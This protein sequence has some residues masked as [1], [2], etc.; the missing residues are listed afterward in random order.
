MVWERRGW[1]GGGRAL[2]GRAALLVRWFSGPAPGCQPRALLLLGDC[3]CACLPTPCLALSSRLHAPLHAPACPPQTARMRFSPLCP[4]C[5]HDE[6]REGEE[7]LEL[8]CSHNYHKDCL[9]PWWVLPWWCAALLG[10]ARAACLQRPCR[11]H[12]GPA[13]LVG[14][15]EGAVAAAAPLP[16]AP[17]ARRAARVPGRAA[18]GFPPLV[19]QAGMLAA[20]S[21]LP[22]PCPAYPLYLPLNCPCP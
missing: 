2:G 4:C 15:P 12:A 14:G 10:A 20:D 8:P 1:G 9:L 13:A 7:V 11:L 16:P 21:G 22:S 19:P 6:F 18:S 3:P 17:P 5:S